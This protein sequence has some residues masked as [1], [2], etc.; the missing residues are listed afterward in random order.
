VISSEG[1]QHPWLAAE[2]VTRLVVGRRL[3]EGP[4]PS[5]DRLLVAVIRWRAGIERAGWFN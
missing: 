5:L 3:E 1:W 2:R 4:T